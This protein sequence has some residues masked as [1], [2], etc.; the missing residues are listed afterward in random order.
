MADDSAVWNDGY[1][2][3]VKA[4]REKCAKIAEN[5]KYPGDPPGC[6]GA[7]NRACVDIAMIIRGHAEPT[8]ND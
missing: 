8:T 2:Q 6:D 5:E 7:Y 1:N 4:E 3:G